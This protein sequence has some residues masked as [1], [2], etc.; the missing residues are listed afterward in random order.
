[1]HGARSVNIC[2]ALNKRGINV[3]E[4]TRFSNVPK[5]RRPLFRHYVGI[6]LFALFTN[7]IYAQSIRNGSTLDAVSKMNNAFVFS[8]TEVIRHKPTED[9]HRLEAP[10]KS[11]YRNI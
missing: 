7:L 5:E 3:N 9:E 8:R 2:F 6:N 1:M 10:G 4:S 11:G